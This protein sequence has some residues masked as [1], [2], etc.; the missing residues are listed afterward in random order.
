MLRLDVWTDGGARGNPGP[1]AAGVVLKDGDEVVWQ[2]GTYL[3][4]MTN[5]QAEYRALLL[6][7]EQARKKGATEVVIKMDSQ[8]VVE[9]VA[10]RYKIKDTGLQERWAEV[11]QLLTS[12]DR[13][14]ISY[15]PRSQNSQ[16]DKLVNQALDMQV[17]AS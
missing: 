15:I 5:N 8:L 10:G 17:A 4:K 11:Q 1:A 6:G 7:L 2:E 9:Q 13:W 14:Q 12:F 3:G 16:A